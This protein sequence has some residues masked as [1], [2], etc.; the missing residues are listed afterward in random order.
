MLVSR[1]MASCVQLWVSNYLPDLQVRRLAITNSISRSWPSADKGCDS[2]HAMIRGALLVCVLATTCGCRGQPPTSGDSLDSYATIQETEIRNLAF[3]L[4]GKTLAIRSGD[5]DLV[6]WDVASR[7]RRA[8]IQNSFSGHNQSIV[9]LFDG[10][11]IAMNAGA[12]IF[13][14][15][16]STGKTTELYRHT[17]PDLPTYLT[18]SS[19]GKMLASCDFKNIIVWDVVKGAKVASF[20]AEKDWDITSM[21]FFQGARTLAG[22]GIQAAGAGNE[23]IW[24]WEISGK[25]KPRFLP[26]RMGL[27]AISA[28]GKSWATLDNSGHFLVWDTETDKLRAK[29]PI[30]IGTIRAI[31]FSPNGKV[32]IAAG[33]HV[34]PFAPRGPGLVAFIDTGTGKVISTAKVLPENVGWMA[35][36][37]D[38]KLLAVSTESPSNEMKVF[39]VSAITTPPKV[40]DDMK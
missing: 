31:S 17:N 8:Q 22:S 2:P 26:G 14:L 12:V 3:S 27:F 30:D 33:G 38:G 32:L 19:D 16:L 21:A 10:K 20:V 29:W 1:K 39:D 25:G 18:A 15:D 37:P 4:D 36:S 40:A 11:G 5:A 35:L 34:P 6:L 13:R 23:G 28:D 24:L 7:T 9:F